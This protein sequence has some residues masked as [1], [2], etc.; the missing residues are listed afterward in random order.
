M[1]QPVCKPAA[2]QASGL[3]SGSSAPELNYR[4]HRVASRARFFAGANT[5]S[6]D[7]LTLVVAEALK[8][9]AQAEIRREVL[10]DALYE[11]PA[12][13]GREREGVRRP[14]YGDSEADVEQDEDPDQ[15]E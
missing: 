13:P 7:L 10:R 2:A 15:D 3:S 6:V 11:M 14:A 9:K 1:K 5:S 12:G 8:R 4:R